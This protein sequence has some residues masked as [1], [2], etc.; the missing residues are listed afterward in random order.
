[1]YSLARQYRLPGTNE[2]K[3]M[4]AVQITERAKGALEKW[5]ISEANAVSLRIQVAETL[6]QEGFS[7]SSF[8]SPKNGGNLAPEAWAYLIDRSLF[9]IGGPEAVTLQAT[10]GKGLAPHQKV[11]KRENRQKAGSVIRDLKKVFMTRWSA[12]HGAPEVPEALEEAPEE[13]V[14]VGK[15]DFSDRVVALAFFKELEGRLMDVTTEQYPIAQVVDLVVE[16]QGV[17]SN[18]KAKR[19]K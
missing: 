9:I 3:T 1:M 2:D 13:A 6:I 17:I 14:K 15:A 19:S 10:P 16:I 12:I 7:P 4:T 5:S 18:S 11:Q 8:Q